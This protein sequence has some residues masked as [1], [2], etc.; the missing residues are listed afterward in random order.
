MKETD[1]YTVDTTNNTVNLVGF[2]AEAGDVITIMGLLGAQSIDFG[3]EAIDAINQINAAVAAAKEELQ[4]AVN[5]ASIDINNLIKQLPSNWDDYLNKNANNV[6]NSGSKITMASNYTPS[7]NYDV[8]T[9]TYVD[10]AIST[11][12][13]NIVTDVF[14]MGNTEDNT[15]KKLLWIDTSDGNG[16]GIIKYHNGSAWIAISSPYT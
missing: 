6:M 10:S 1:N 16:N 14:Y 7:G 9:K 12:T 2:S 3:Q 11:A 15:K 13:S 4:D 8:T 5:Q